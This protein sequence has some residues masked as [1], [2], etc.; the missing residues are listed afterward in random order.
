VAHFAVDGHGVV[1]G[2]S[3][4]VHLQLD[5]LGHGFTLL[6]LRN[7]GS[8]YAE[9]AIRA[10]VH[11]LSGPGVYPMAGGDSYARVWCPTA[12][13]GTKMYAAAGV[14]G[15]VVTIAS[16]DTVTGMVEGGFRFH[17]EPWRGDGEGQ[18]VT[19]GY[20]RGIVERVGDPVGA[21]V[22]RLRP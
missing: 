16:F 15:D 20:F 13:G 17:A 4:E 12:G 18:I 6:A 7:E 8:Y 10:D 3:D 11:E 1:F 5:T 19:N 22:E 14:P 2:S 9:R 21:D